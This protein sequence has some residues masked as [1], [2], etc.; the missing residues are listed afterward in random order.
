MATNSSSVR[1]FHCQKPIDD[2]K[3]SCPHCGASRTAPLCP[4]C[5][6]AV[7]AA[8]D[9]RVP[10]GDGE[11]FYPW[12]FG[13]DGRCVSCGK[14]FTA[15][16]DV[17]TGHTVFFKRLGGQPSLLERFARSNPNGGE[18]AIDIRGGESVY[19]M[20]DY[21]SHQPT[22]EVQIHRAVAAMRGTKRAG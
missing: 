5:G 3:A 6:N 1:C 8:T 12:H 4:R 15:H 16:V 17:D 19:E 10:V 14:Q 13:W 22:I 2:S 21:W 11:G 9:R 18:S 7:T 20:C